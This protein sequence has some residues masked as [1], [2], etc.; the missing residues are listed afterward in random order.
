MCP[1]VEVCSD[2]GGEII[3]LYCKECTFGRGTEDDTYFRYCRCWNI[4]SC[5]DNDC[6]H[7]EL[8]EEIKKYIQSE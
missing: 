2:C 5:G 8:R 4:L 1:R 3:I 6:S 7:K